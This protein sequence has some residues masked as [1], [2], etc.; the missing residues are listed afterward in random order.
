MLDK[1]WDQTLQLIAQSEECALS[2]VGPA[3]LQASFVPCRVQNGTLYIGVLA[4]SDHLFNLEHTSYVV[5][6]TS[7]WELHGNAMPPN[8]A[9][10]PFTPDEVQWHTLFA[11]S[12][13]RVNALLETADNSR[14]TIDFPS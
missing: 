1:L 3:G 10:T 6:T 2:T 4:T 12:V 14:I 5:L 8:P 9:D 7:T 11:I 13:T